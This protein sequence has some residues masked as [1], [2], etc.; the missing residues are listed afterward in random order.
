MTV[1]VDLAEFLG[2]VSVQPGP[3]QATQRGIERI[4]ELL[5]AELVAV[6]RAGC[7]A[8]VVGSPAGALGE[9]DLRRLTEGPTDQPATRIDLVTA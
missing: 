8:I 3:A 7:E 1:K 2:A 4:R 6:V 5:E 9:H